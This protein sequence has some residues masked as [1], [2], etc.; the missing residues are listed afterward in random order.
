[1][2]IVC[3]AGGIVRVRAVEFMC[4]KTRE[5]SSWFLV[6][7]QLNSAAWPP[8]PTRANKQ[9][10]PAIMYEFYQPRSLDPLSS[11]LEKVLGGERERTLHGNEV[12]ILPLDRG[13]VTPK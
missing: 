1:M 5:E 11:S 4:A 7:S 10:P 3:V 12:G 9:K 8:F 13:T 6:A 2:D